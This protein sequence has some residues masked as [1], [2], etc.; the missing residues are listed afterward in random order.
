MS[1]TPSSPA[2]ENV[3]ASKSAIQYHYDVGNRF[4]EAFLGRSMAYSAAAWTEPANRDTLDDA[5]ARK[6]DWF[7]DQAGLVDGATVLEIGC[8]WGSLLKRLR[9]RRINVRY[10]G[11]TLSDAQAEYVSRSLPGAGEIHVMPWQAYQPNRPFDAIIAIEAIEHFTTLDLSKVQRLQAYRDFFGFCA[12]RLAPGSRLCL[13][14][15]T[16]FNM[17]PG[18]ERKYDFTQFFPET[19]PPRLGELFTASEEH[20]HVTRVEGVPRD[21]IYTLRAWIR[22]LRADEAALSQQLG[23]QRVQHY[24]ANF[25]LMLNAFL[26]GGISLYRMGLERHRTSAARTPG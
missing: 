20:F 13:Q 3:G 1:T 21:F 23:P 7:I 6:L 14:M 25:T 17:D 18:E 19:N 4:Y 24:I 11:L 8:G 10:V 22:A 26:A 5:Q 9:A 12:D 2:Y 15:T 16:W